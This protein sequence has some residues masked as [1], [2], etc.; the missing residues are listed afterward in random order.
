MPHRM[1]RFGEGLSIMVFRRFPS[2]A[3]LFLSG[4]TPSSLE[5]TT[6]LLEGRVFL[7]KVGTFPFQLKFRYILSEN[8]AASNE[9]LLT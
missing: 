4:M 8:L 7:F 1:Y 2:H 6:F 3:S 9:K 5:V